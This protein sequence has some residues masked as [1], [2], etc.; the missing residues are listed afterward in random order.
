[1]S[2]TVLIGAQQRAHVA[3]EPAISGRWFVCMDVLIKAWYYGRGQHQCLTDLSKVV[4]Q[5]EEPLFDKNKV[6][7][8]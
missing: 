6:D 4:S 1:M 5:L 2:R 7:E 8:A 3:T